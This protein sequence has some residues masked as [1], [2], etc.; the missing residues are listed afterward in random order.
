MFSEIFEEIVQFR[1]SNRSFDPHTKIPQEVIEKSLRRATLSPNSSNMQLWEFH[2]IESK[3]EI[4]KFIP[5]CLH[6][7]AAKTAD[8]M[9]VFVTRL[10]KYKE[11]AAWNHQMILK[12]IDGEPT[13]FQK[14]ALQYYKKLMPLLYAH[15]IF[16]IMGLGRKAISFFSGLR[17]PFYRA[18]GRAEQR[19]VA[20]KSCALAAQTFML[21]I[22]AEG[23]HSCPM[24]GFDEIRVKKLLG[25]PAAAE[26]NMIISVGRGTE[27]G[28]WGPRFRVPFDEVV[29][30]H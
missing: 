26:I 15:D 17:K 21:S 28:V 5:L 27:A 16:G 25:L 9:V 14:G 23:Y 3:T 13:R 18:G 22:A 30:R 7:S 4:E 12:S 24:E 20:H 2:W 29:K 19:I 10:D 11:R 8:Q 6:Q 1:R